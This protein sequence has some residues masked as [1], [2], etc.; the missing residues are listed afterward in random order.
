MNLDYVI[1][2]NLIK[3]SKTILGIQHWGKVRLIYKGQG[4]IEIET[5][6]LNLDSN[7]RMGIKN[8]I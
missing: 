1:N 4:T 7:N 3:V 2:P 5:K 8:Y 6:C